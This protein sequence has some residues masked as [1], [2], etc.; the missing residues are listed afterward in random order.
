[1][2]DC[3]EGIVDKK[4]INSRLKPDLEGV[5]RLRSGRAAVQGRNLGCWRTMR[6]VDRLSCGGVVVQGRDCSRNM[7]SGFC[8]LGEQQ[9]N[10]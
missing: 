9:I 10:T 4:L 8:K 3:R 7:R 2:A 5:G 6:T 1:M